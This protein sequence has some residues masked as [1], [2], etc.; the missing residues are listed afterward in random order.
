MGQERNTMNATTTMNPAAVTVTPAA[1]LKNRVKSVTTTIDGISKTAVRA[2]NLRRAD[3]TGADAKKE[4]A[5]YSRRLLALSVWVKAAAAVA[6][7]D[8]NGY[9]AARK[10]AYVALKGLADYICN[11]SGVGKIALKK[12]DVDYLVRFGYNRRVNRN[13][14]PA[15]PISDT[16][17]P[18]TV[19]VKSKSGL[20]ALVEDIMYFRLNGLDVPA[21]ALTTNTA[22]ALKKAREADAAAAA[23]KA[24]AKAAADMQASIEAAARQRAEREKA[25]QLNGPAAAPAAPAEKPAA[26]TGKGKGKKAA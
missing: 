8:E 10:P 19:T 18:I 23:K 26:K 7:D 24:A 3:F 12:S 22:E 25:E 13:F 11:V 17:T 9:F 14:D 4:W 6:D 5:G 15:A 1:L 16:N 20:Q 21:V 2:V